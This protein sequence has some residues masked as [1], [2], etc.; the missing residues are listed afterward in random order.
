MCVV[1]RAHLFTCIHIC[2]HMYLCKY[3]WYVHISVYM[4]LHV[5]ICM[6]GLSSLKCFWLIIFGKKRIC[7]WTYIIYMEGNSIQAFLGIPP[8]SQIPGK[9]SGTSFPLGLEG[10]GSLPSLGSLDCHRGWCLLSPCGPSPESS[11]PC[12]S[13]PSLCWVSSFV[14]AGIPVTRASSPV[15][16]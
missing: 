8:P 5:Y 2:V 4:C 7:F 6:C 16:L 9:T 3:I 12:L 10:T 15:D 13:S 1:L 14:R 11:W